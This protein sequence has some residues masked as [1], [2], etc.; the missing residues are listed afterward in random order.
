MDFPFTKTIL[1][2]T[3]LSQFVFKP[4][5][6]FIIIK[7]SKGSSAEPCGTADLINLIHVNSSTL[8]H[9]VICLKKKN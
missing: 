8:L 6:S 5:I 7:N 3:K 9:Y 2:S 1:A 4:K